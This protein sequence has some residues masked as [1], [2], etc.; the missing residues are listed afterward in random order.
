M[1]AFER[2]DRLAIAPF[3]LLSYAIELR[4][5]KSL[6]NPPPGVMEGPEPESFRTPPPMAL[7]VVRSGISVAVMKTNSSWSLVETVLDLKSVPIKGRSPR[8]GTLLDD[9]VSFLEF[10]PAMTIVSPFRTMA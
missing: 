4:Q 7:F 3:P 2:N 6:Y 9:T 5:W 10:S 1:L 8:I